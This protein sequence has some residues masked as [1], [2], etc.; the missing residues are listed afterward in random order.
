M[1]ISE[2]KDGNVPLTLPSSSAVTATEP[3]HHFDVISMRSIVFNRLIPN[4]LTEEVE[5][6]TLSE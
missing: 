1:F 5:D 4:W 3:W 6:D 2:N